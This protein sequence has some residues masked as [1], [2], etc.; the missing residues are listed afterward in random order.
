MDLCN[1][2]RNI[3]NNYNNPN[4][5]NKTDLSNIMTQTEEE[6]TKKCDNSKQFLKEAN[7]NLFD[8]TDLSKPKDK[9]KDNQKKK[10]KT[11][12]PK[13]FEDSNLYQKSVQNKKKKLKFKQPFI[14]YVNIESFKTFNSMMCFSDP[15]MQGKTKKCCK[16]IIF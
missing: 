3:D 6:R 5:T 9:D 2:S 10:P 14:E 11:K 7:N 16:C 8:L 12:K 4:G 15:H 1:Y 13:V